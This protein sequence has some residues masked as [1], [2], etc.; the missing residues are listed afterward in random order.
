MSGIISE[1]KH[2]LSDLIPI[3]QHDTLLARSIPDV[4]ITNITCDSRKVEENSV[5]CAIKG[6]KNDGHDYIESVLKSNPALVFAE[7]YTGSNE[8]VINVLDTR[9]SWALLSSAWFGFPANKMKFLGVTGTNG[10]TTTALIVQHLLA[11][12]NYAFRPAYIGTLGRLFQSELIPGNLTTPDAFILHENFEYLAKHGCTHVVMEVS[13]H[14]L[15]QKRTYGINYLAAAFTNLTQ[16][17]LDFHK[18]MD[19]Y[20]KSKAILFNQYLTDPSTQSAIIN[21]DDPNG[22]FYINEAKCH[23]IPYSTN[24]VNI[25]GI[26]AIDINLGIDGSNFKLI[27]GTKSTRVSL[28]LPGHFNIQNALAAAGLA[29]ASGLTIDEI[30]SGLNSFKNVPGRVEKVEISSKQDFTVLVDYAHTPDALNNVLKMLNELKTSES[31]IITVFGCGGDRDHDKRPKMGSVVAQLSD[32]AIITSDN[33]RTEEPNSIIEMIIPGVKTY[34]K[35]FLVDPDRRTAIR[36]AIQS[37]KKGDIVLI[38]GK[39]HEDY[40]I[41]GKEKIHFDDREIAAEFLHEVF[42]GNHES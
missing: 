32:L 26:S 19:D 33:P 25:N 13:S 28:A 4:V 36:L 22:E 39:G 10:K 18:S 2:K 30:T 23:V 16:D 14:A 40:Q 42:D 20:K 7:K 38:A 8:K 3:T 31:K 17:H 24:Q 11:K 12:A 6:D 15:K 27:I 37:A 1:M 41:I 21:I 34:K 9:L 35:T 29:L 5:F